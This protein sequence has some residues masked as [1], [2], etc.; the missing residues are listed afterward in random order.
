MESKAS[1]DP[2]LHGVQSFSFGRL[3]DS[4]ALALDGS[5]TAHG[6]QSFSFGRLMESKALALDGSWSP[7]L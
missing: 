7:K 1:W 2:T 4:K 3:M 6:V 5:W